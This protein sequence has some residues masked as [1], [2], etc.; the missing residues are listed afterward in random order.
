MEIEEEEAEEEKEEEEEEMED[1]EDAEM[2]EKVVG[3]MTLPSHC[4]FTRKLLILLL[5]Q[6]P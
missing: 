1:E 3:N 2:E 4:A 5:S 6:N